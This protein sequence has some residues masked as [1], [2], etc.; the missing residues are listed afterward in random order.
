M[1]QRKKGTFTEHRQCND[2]RILCP[3][4][5]PVQDVQSISMYMQ[6]HCTEI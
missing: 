3:Y 4:Y 1:T 5:R 2:C 6:L